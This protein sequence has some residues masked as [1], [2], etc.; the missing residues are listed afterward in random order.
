MMEE[1]TKDEILRTAVHIRM[2]L[3]MR[4]QQAKRMLERLAEHNGQ[5]PSMG[6][7]LIDSVKRF[8]LAVLA[9]DPKEISTRMEQMLKHPFAEYVEEKGLP[10]ELENIGLARVQKNVLKGGGRRPRSRE[11]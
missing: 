8:Q 11:K 4:A 5:D 10:K 3:E 6:M 1:V 7:D 9:C 2:D